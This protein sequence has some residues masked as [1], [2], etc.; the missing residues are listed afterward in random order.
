MTDNSPQPGAEKDRD[1]FGDFWAD[2]RYHKIEK[3]NWDNSPNPA[4]TEVVEVSPILPT[5]SAKPY[6]IHAETTEYD[7]SELELLHNDALDTSHFH[8]IEGELRERSSLTLDRRRLVRERLYFWSRRQLKFLVR[9]LVALIAL[10]CA[11]YL[12][13]P[14]VV[15]AILQNVLKDHLDHFEIE[16][17]GWDVLNK[18][19]HLRNV[20][21]SVKEFEFSGDLDIEYRWAELISCGVEEVRIFGSCKLPGERQLLVRQ[22]QIRQLDYDIFSKVLDIE[23]VSASIAIV[24]SASNSPAA[25]FKGAACRLDQVQIEGFRWNIDRD[26]MFARRLTS[27]RSEVACER[28]SNGFLWLAG[29]NL[30][31]KSGDEKKSNEFPLTIVVDQ[32][33]LD[34][35]RA[36]WQDKL[37]TDPSPLKVFGDFKIA[38]GLQIVGKGGRIRKTDNKFEV[39][40]GFKQAQKPLSVA[41]HIDLAPPFLTFFVERALFE[42]LPL[43]SLDQLLELL[44]EQLGLKDLEGNPLLSGEVKGTLAL[45]PDDLSIDISTRRPI[46]I[47]VDGEDVATIKKLKLEGLRFNDDSIQVH[48]A[49]GQFSV[50]IEDSKDGAKIAALSFAKPFTGGLKR[51]RL[52]LDIALPK[53]AQVVQKSLNQCPWTFSWSLFPADKSSEKSD[54]P[55]FSGWVNSGLVSLPKGQS[56]QL[57]GDCFV[58]VRDF[59]LELFKNGD[60]F[61]PEDDKTWPSLS[62][63]A[64]GDIAVIN[65]G[66]VVKTLE[67]S[68]LS[69]KTK[70][71]E[72]ASLDQLTINN[73]QFDKSVKRY[74]FGALNLNGLKLEL[75]RRKKHY[76]L[77]GMKWRHDLKQSNSAFRSDN[78]RENELGA[79][80]EIGPIEVKDIHVSYTDLVEGIALDDLS[81]QA[82]LPQGI[83]PNKDFEAFA[84]LRLEDSIVTVDG[85]IDPK[86]G[87]VI[88]TIAANRL[89]A[90]V[91]NKAVEFLAWPGLASIQSQA[92]MFDF[93]WGTEDQRLLGDI[94]LKQLGWT[95]E[96]RAENILHKL[97]VSDFT[98]DFK[99]KLV[100]GV[101]SVEKLN[102]IASFR[103]LKVVEGRSEAIDLVTDRCRLLMGEQP[104]L[105]IKN[106]VFTDQSGSPLLKTAKFE[107][108]APLVDKQRSYEVRVERPFL[109][110]IITKEV[111]QFCGA[112]VNFAE[113]RKRLLLEKQKAAQSSESSTKDAA[114]QS[115]T[116]YKV[117]LH[118][119][120]L[121][122]RERAHDKPF[123]TLV[124]D[125][126]IERKHGSLDL[127]LVLEGLQG[128]PFHRLSVR[129][130]NDGSGFDVSRLSLSKLRLDDLGTV[131]ERHTDYRGVKGLID[132]E[133][134]KES[135]KD[136]K[137][138]LNDL[139]VRFANDSLSGKQL[140]TSAAA[141][142][143]T[144]G[145]FFF[146]Q[147]DPIELEI[148]K[149]ALGLGAGAQEEGL[150]AMTGELIKLGV[151]AAIKPI[152]SPTT[153]VTRLATEGVQGLL[154]Q[155]DDEHEKIAGSNRT[156]LVDFFPASTKLT[157]SGEAQIAEISALYKKVSEELPQL[158]LSLTAILGQTDRNRI[159]SAFSLK[160]KDFLTMIR[161]FN[162]RAKLLEL[163][164]HETL[165][166]LSTSKGD[167]RQ[168]V[169]EKSTLIGQKISRYRREIRM[170]LNLTNKSGI[171]KE[172]LLRRQR[173]ILLT[174]RVKSTAKLLE[175]SG[176]AKDR[177]EILVSGQDRGRGRVEVEIRGF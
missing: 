124:R 126:Q 123:I 46:N 177:I 163:Q 78:D 113:I 139:R 80:F 45:S 30:T 82:R 151:K 84:R 23:K 53:G 14:Y 111:A 55:L 114:Q 18:K 142:L 95:L 9:A 158:S 11:F 27:P 76:V 49:L 66:V 5:L 96:D 137:L 109:D 118:R 148:P 54:E 72:T 147:P 165:R 136:L 2:Q 144:N 44:P 19:F 107:C 175:K 4:V 104:E 174:L 112:Q 141:F 169:A 75:E 159:E 56:V 85:I 152:L 138:V 33:D 58:K 120:R 154:D 101:L 57:S 81:F 110:L 65:S 6:E 98:Y 35:I 149:S 20:Q 48:S 88:G 8:E 143:L 168:R 117:L 12:S 37:S 3:S 133:T 129:G 100:E 50:L 102:L 39:H 162:G 150:S 10:L 99:D 61:K 60:Q 38:Q 130:A 68:D 83:V 157:P 127:S 94:T 31:K 108:I 173:K 64:W 25:A 69:L 135:P 93:E 116:R 15:P 29:F 156:V 52:E 91:S 171:E 40:L 106:L 32:V 89:P 28:D 13:V 1:N 161:R 34:D 51:S 115:P 22:A 92:I 122:L 62:A 125:V 132:L 167:V 97:T 105:I 63:E 164:R 43:R 67:I 71:K 166:Q 41:A 36:T 103:G 86:K 74:R 153:F 146:L 128:S 121:R 16:S 26:Q 145:D 155:F 70:N 21:G 131:I 172:K 24:S 79:Y 176:V 59:S 17:F 47:T 7:S 42:K 87:A 73:F 90:W 134:I 160:N 77:A 170:L 119:G 140:V